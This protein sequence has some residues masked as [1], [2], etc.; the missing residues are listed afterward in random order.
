MDRRTIGG[1]TLE[2]PGR[3][4]LKPLI[5]VG[6]FAVLLSGCGIAAKVNARND[7]QAS[8]TAYKTCLAQHPQDIAAC[9][10]PRQAY[11]ADLSAYQA[12]SAATRPGPIYSY[13]GEPAVASPALAPMPQPVAP[14]PVPELP[15]VIGSSMHSCINSGSFTFCR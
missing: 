11:E 15:P 4:Q 14:M 3:E 1:R 2:N 13:Q 9:E 10:G 6:A 7:M 5:I 8:R 12:T